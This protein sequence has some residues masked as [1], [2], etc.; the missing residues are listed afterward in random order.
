[1]LTAL[2]QAR[3]KSRP[4]GCG[5]ALLDSRGNVRLVKSCPVCLNN[6]LDFL[7]TRCYTAKDV[8]GMSRERQLDM[9]EE[10]ASAEGPL[11]SL[12]GGE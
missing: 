2:Q 12:Q 6:A 4:C 3:L 11:L 7:K 8:R 10:D 1:M 5:E 9:F